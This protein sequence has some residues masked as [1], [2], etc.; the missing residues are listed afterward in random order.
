MTYYVFP[1]GTP[2]HSTRLYA[3]L[4][5]EMAAPFMPPGHTIQWRVDGS[6]IPNKSGPTDD[7]AYLSINSKTGSDFELSAA[8][9]GSTVDFV[10]DDTVFSNPVVISNQTPVLSSAGPAVDAFGLM[11]PTPTVSWDFQDGDGDA[12]AFYRVRLGTSFGSSDIYDSGDVLSAAGFYPFPAITALTRGQTYYWKIE[13]GDGALVNP[14]DPGSDYVRVSANGATKVNSL[15]VAINVKVD[16]QSGGNISSSTPTVSWSY[17]DPDGQP[18]TKFRV[19]VGQ[20]PL[21]D[22]HGNTLGIQNHNA[23]AGNHLPYWNSGL[24]SGDRTSVVYN[25]DGTGFPLTAHSAIVFG[26]ALADSLETSPYFATT[27]VTMASKPQITLLTVNSKVN[28]TNLISQ[29][30][31]FDWEFTDS[32]GDPLT[33]FEI[34]ISR[35]N[36][37]LGT[38]TFVG[39]LWNT[40]PVVSA[41]GTEAQFNFDGRAFP[42]TGTDRELLPGA[43]YYFQV[44]VTDAYDKSDWATGYFKL[45][46]KPRADNLRVLPNP[47]YHSDDLVVAYDFVD[48]NG[49]AESSLTKI[50]WFKNPP[51]G[52]H[53]FTQV[54]VADLE[55][56]RIVPSS[57]LKPGDTWQ[58]QVIPHDGTSYG[59]GNSSSIVTILNHTPQVANPI[60]IPAFPKAS[61]YL[62]AEFD[63]F[64]A[65][66]DASLTSVSLTW[67]RNGEEQPLFK[68]SKRIPPY[69]VT[70]GE[71]WYYTATPFDGYSFGNTATSPNAVIANTKPGVVGI[72]VDGQVSPTGIQSTNPTISWAYKDGDGQPQGKYQVLIG[73]SGLKVAGARRR[74]VKAH[75]IEYTTPSGGDILS[76]NE[77]FDSG[78]TQGED[79]SIKYATDDNLPELTIH[80]G[81]FSV[82]R[83]YLS[84][85]Q[86][87]VLYL[88][89]GVP[90]GTASLR[91]QGS[92]SLYSLSIEYEKENVASTF[93]ILVDGILLGTVATSP[94]SG[95]EIK[96]IGSFRVQNGST[97]SVIGHSMQSSRAR[98]NSLR[99]KPVVQFDVQA[100]DFDSLSGYVSDGTDGIKLSGLAGTATLKFP[101]PSGEYD[102]EIV[103]VTETTG[104]PSLSLSV[105]GTVV[106]SFSYETGAKVRTKTISGLSLDDGDSIRLVGSRNLSAAARVKRVTFKPTSSI[107]LG[108]KLNP[109]TQYFVSV[110]V[111]DGLDWGDWYTSIFTTAGSAWKSV[112]HE[113]GWTIDFGV[114]LN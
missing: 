76:G 52:P 17:S 110:R 85:Q 28:P 41:Q 92:S 13:V 111:F 70:V 5:S 102:V 54:P 94:G 71:T 65:D 14:L 22:V 51:T 89:P 114:I 99:L 24:I 2:S 69:V 10:I 98:F 7:V 57:Y 21:I 4:D 31:F 46:V 18:Q 37:A 80:P 93:N 113:V 23:G 11:T 44:Q 1:S 55:N 86:G 105:N 16:G 104:S 91:F 59:D 12:Q 68:N 64:D 84:D 33:G 108:G 97:L 6:P 56:K 27:T 49:D 39:D 107:A 103:Y 74:V 96:S 36:T 77:V 15:P 106:S 29:Y 43:I 50:L 66:G 87:D 25:D 32:D 73:T 34:R 63:V 109:G 45:N 26:V 75:G 47:A 3:R 112:S 81:D 48:D 19:L 60:I 72:A 82:F 95:R 67:Y 9:A 101:F 38:D 30:P 78:P 79:S 20:V 88:K 61:D 90:D 100:L 62:Q 40:G 83:N 42:L 35:D 58:V 53:F 8:D